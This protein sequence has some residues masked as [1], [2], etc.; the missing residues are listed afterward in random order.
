MRKLLLMGMT[1]VL[2]VAGARAGEDQ[3]LLTIS[4]MFG[5]HAVLQRDMPVPVWGW[6]APG[7]VVTVAFAG[8][9]K[10]A[11]SGEDGK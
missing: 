4:P 5:D 6:G 2:M 7:T 9:Q 1:S 10:T 8:Q 3:S 11:T